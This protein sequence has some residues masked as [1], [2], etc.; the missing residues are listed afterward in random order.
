MRRIFPVLFLLLSACFVFA[1]EKVPLPETKH[2]LAVIAHRGNHVKVPENTVAAV[3]AA[4]KSGADYA[5]IDLRTTKDGYLVIHHDATVDRMTNGTGNIKDL[6]LAELKQLKV[7]DKNK[8]TKKTYRIPTFR[9]VLEAAKG[10]INIYLDFKDA[11]VAETYRQIADA[12]MEKQVAVYVNTIPQ[13]REWRKTAPGIPLIASVIEEVKNKDQ[14]LFFLEQ[15]TIEVLDNVSDAEMLAAAN[16][17]GVA[18]WLDVQSDD[19]APGQWN[20]ALQ[21]GIQGIQTDHPEALIAYLNRSGLRNGLGKDLTKE[22]PYAKY[23]KKTY[24]ELKNIKYG[25]APGDANM[26]DAYFPKEMG[27]NARVIVY[28]HGGGW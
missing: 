18:V 3:K 20:G 15:G 24:R 19:E 8:P 5:E 23:K 11:G 26:L 16:D 10:K 12:G 9:E 22:D 7:A 25:K 14:L 28:I 13:Y 27:P 17:N 6:T 21:K 4:V 1:Q 2:K